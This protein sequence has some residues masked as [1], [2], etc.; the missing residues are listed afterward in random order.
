MMLE[1]SSE[2]MD[3]ANRGT[4]V[5]Y[6]AMP[7]V[8]VDGRNIIKLI[9][10]QRVNGRFVQ[11]IPVQ[12]ADKE[13]LQPSDT[14]HFIK[15]QLPLINALPSQ[16]GVTGNILNKHPLHQKAI[17]VEAKS[18]TVTVKSP[19]GQ[20]LQ[21]PP[22]PQVR[23][24]M[25]ELSQDFNREIFTL[26]TN[27]STSSAAVVSPVTMVTPPSTS[28]FHLL[29]L[30]PNSSTTKSTGPSA[31]GSK[32]HLKLIPK[33]PQRPNSPIKWVIEEEVSTAAALSF[34]NYPSITSE[35][36]HT[37]AR[38]E[39]AA[40]SSTKMAA[41]SQISPTNC[42]GGQ[43]HAPVMCNGKV[44]VAK[45]CTLP[46]QMEKINSHTTHRDESDKT[47]LCATRSQSS[48]T[49]QNVPNESEEVIDLCD[50]DS[51]D[52]LSQ[53][54]TSVPCSMSAPSKQDEDNVIFVSYIPPKSESTSEKHMIQE[55]QFNKKVVE[56]EMEQR[57]VRSSSESVSGQK[58]SCNQAGTSGSISFGSKRSCSASSM[59]LCRPTMKNLCD[60]GS[61]EM[62]SQCRTSTQ[63]LESPEADAG[64][65]SPA[66]RS[67]SGSSGPSRTSFP[68]QKE[69][70]EVERN[71]S[72]TWTQKSSQTSELLLRQ[73]FG[74]TKCA[75]ICLQRIDTI[76]SKEY[77][78][79]ESITKHSL[80]FV[81]K[82]AEESAVLLTEKKVKESQDLNDSQE[83]NGCH[84]PDV[85][86]V[87]LQTEQE[88]SAADKLG[89]FT[90]FLTALKDKS[91]STERSHDKTLCD[92]DPVSGFG[93]PIEEEDLPS[94]DKN[95]SVN[96]LIMEAHPQA[97]IKT[98][99]RRMGRVRKPTICPCYVL[100]TS[101]EDSALHSRAK[102]EKCER[103]AEQA[104]KKQGRMSG[105]R[106]RDGKASGRILY[107]TAKN[108]QSHQTSSEI[109]GSDALFTTCMD[110]E[111]LERH[112][113]IK[114]L[115]ELLR[116][117]E[118]ALEMMR[119][120][121]I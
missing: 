27:S 6:Q 65:E 10:V 48:Q 103:M 101:C 54:E 40:K 90:C 34:L 32:T 46:F 7:A 107:P 38:R 87:K 12:M 55:T 52:D 111:E 61:L 5:F 17:H 11:T 3:A 99:R 110:S 105:S 59:S 33:L 108:T 75:K 23:V 100:S 44:F 96:S 76:K 70:Q 22:E 53:Q 4:G 31:G 92:A 2:D 67:T 83:S 18:P 116:E 113:Q 114:R 57:G 25:S 8:G 63:Q 28:S 106:R 37:V 45:K 115:K 35:V 88:V 74:I 95:H 47:I 98:N 120:G 77:L 102:L 79:N 66:G 42:G 112:K 21:I 94:T 71:S 73:I 85:K 29:Q 19:G 49:G 24:L 84:P 80:E 39:N 43:D 20:N 97:L 58:M 117:K 68:V 60:N 50:D 82:S 69:T 36:L 14:Q 91:V 119:T 118:A 26:S 64:M 104:S 62:E 41:S 56:K 13:I 89:P 9:P 78:Q 86:R 51:Q 30:V 16:A 109:P 1:S 72:P 81:L 121:V 93:E 15:K